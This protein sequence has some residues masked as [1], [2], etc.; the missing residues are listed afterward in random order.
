[1]I[2]EPSAGGVGMMQGRA[3]GLTGSAG[4]RTRKQ[5]RCPLPPGFALAVFPA[6]D[7]RI[8][9]G[10]LNNKPVGEVHGKALGPR[11]GQLAVVVMGYNPDSTWTE[12]QE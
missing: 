1:M 6:A 8:G 9:A 5:R 12:V 11:S 7:G 3:R 4:R 2:V 10:V